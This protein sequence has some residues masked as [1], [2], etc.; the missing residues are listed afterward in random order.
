MYQSSIASVMIATAILATVVD[1][2][3]FDE[4]KYPNWTSQWRAVE[5]SPPRYDPSKP[6]GRGQQAPLKPEYQAFHEASMADQAAG[7][8]GLETNYKCIPSGMPKQ[9][10]GSPA[11]PFEFVLTPS[12]TFILFDSPLST[13]RRIYTDGRD[14]PKDGQ[15]TFAGYSLGKWI[16]E[17]GGGRYNVL[18]VETR[19]LK[20]PRVFD[21][22]GIP[23]HEDNQTVIKERIYLDK[24]NSNMLHN[25]ITT[26]D[27][28]LTRPWTVMKNYGREPKVIWYEN[29]CGE[30]NN[31]VAIGMEVYYLSGDGH[32][33]PAKKDQAPPDLRYFSRAVK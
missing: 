31:R 18:E 24:A 3:A 8:M 14:W 28:A 33:M 27:H 26:I 17:E 1:A 7:G 15:P 4:A 25:E 16:D 11:N 23:M 13:T 10:N 6:D 30:G 9:M 12:T 5:R 32:L 21:D 29:N 22:T 19:N 20:G 2:H